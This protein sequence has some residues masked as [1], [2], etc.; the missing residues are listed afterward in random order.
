MLL[1]IRLEAGKNDQIFDRM[2]QGFSTAK[3]GMQSEQRRLTHASLPVG[4]NRL[5]TSD[6]ALC[7]WIGVT[8]KCFIE[9]NMNLIG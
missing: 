4:E 8:K 3:M 6:P 9:T 7:Y 5:I 1:V 2:C